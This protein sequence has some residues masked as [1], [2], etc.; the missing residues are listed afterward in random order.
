MGLQKKCIDKER[1]LGPTLVMYPYYATSL[2]KRLPTMKKWQ[3]R[4]NVRML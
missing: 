4:K 3:K 2:I 1:E